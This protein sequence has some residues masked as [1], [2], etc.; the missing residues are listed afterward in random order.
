MV[1]SPPLHVD[2][3]QEFALE[4]VMED[5]GLPHFGP[6]MEVAELLG[7]RGNWLIQMCRKANSLRHR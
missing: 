1:L 7:S 5:F 4:A 6:G 3:T 2:H